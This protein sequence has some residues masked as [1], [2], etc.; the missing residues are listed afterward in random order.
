[1]HAGIAPE[2]PVRL[3]EVNRAVARAIRD[4][5]GAVSGLQAARL[6]AFSATLPQIVSAAAAHIG[7][8]SAAISAGEALDARIT[9]DYVDQLNAVVNIGRGPL[10]AAAGPMWYRGLSQTSTAATATEV[11]ALLTR[12]GAARM[13]VGHTPRLPGQIVP[14]F[15]NRVFPIDTGMLSSYFKGGRPSALEIVGD[16]VTAIYVGAREVLVDN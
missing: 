14:R 7:R 16:R 8:I 13:V 12:L 11:G 2:T 3:D 6:I 5:D 9:R 4:W 1:M 15:D 10:L